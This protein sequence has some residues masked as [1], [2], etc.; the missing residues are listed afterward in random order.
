MLKILCVFM[1]WV[2]FVNSAYAAKISAVDT[3]NSAPASKAQ[4]IKEQ[5]VQIPA[6]SKVEVR[7]TNK[8][9]LKGR[10]GAVSD[11]GIVLK[12]IKADRT[13]ERKIT[14]AE[15]TSIKAVKGLSK[16]AIGLLVGI[17]VLV[18]VVLAADAAVGET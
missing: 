18:I 3:A 16:A 17:G 2:V 7:L 5:A 6:G 8:E 1:A 4:T 15:M 12:S 14:F 9:K 10:L 13:E 11:E